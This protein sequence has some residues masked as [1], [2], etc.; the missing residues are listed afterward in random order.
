MSKNKKKQPAG[1]PPGPSSRY[2]FFL[3]MTSFLALAGL[4]VGIDYATI[5]P[6]AEA[7]FIWKSITNAGHTNI[8]QDILSTIPSE[9][10]YWLL[11]YRLPGLLLYALGIYLF[12]RWGR[13]LFGTET[14][15]VT[16]LL[17]AASL[18]LQFLAKVASLDAAR[19]GLEL[20]F[21]VA[22]MHYF[23]KPEREW[24]VPTAIL[25]VAAILVGQTATLIVV[26]SWWMGYFL[27]LKKAEGSR[28]Q[29]ALPFLFIIGV[30]AV[31]FLVSVLNPAHSSMMLASYFHPFKLSFLKL[32]FFTFLGLAPFI[33]FAFAAIRDLIY[34]WRKGEELAMLVGVGMIG[35]F[36]GQSLVFPF[37]LT[38][39]TAK[40]VINYFKIENYPWQNWVKGGQVLHLL[41]FFMVAV[42]LLVGGT[43]NF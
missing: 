2:R 30:F 8:L 20:G 17:V 21:W 7:Y 24:L 38:F 22:L 39:L 11:A 23:K 10:E 25:G 32:L 28:P 1:P 19:F 42:L 4:L 41:V 18:L 33:G 35:A 3:W 9:S 36:L 27:L 26:L 31:D 37:L 12:F 29:V 15:Q 14:V 6:D 5:W 16:L 40:Q 13:S 43:F 34:K